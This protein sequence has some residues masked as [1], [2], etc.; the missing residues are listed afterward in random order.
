MAGLIFVVSI[1]VAG[2]IMEG[3]YVT[4][5]LLFGAHD[6]RVCFTLVLSSIKT[7]CNLHMSPPC[8]EDHIIYSKIKHKSS[9]AVTLCFKVKI[10]LRFCCSLFCLIHNASP[11][12]AEDNSDTA[13]CNKHIIRGHGICDSG[14]CQI[15]G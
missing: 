3:C 12:N 15:E 2:L 5:H 14:G 1:N 8:I 4:I 13:C 9:Q 6:S 10:I 11:E 7:L